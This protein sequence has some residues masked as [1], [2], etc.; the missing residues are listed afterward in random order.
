MD[1]LTQY[2]QDKRKELKNI[3]S[4]NTA[5]ERLKALDSD[6]RKAIEEHENTWLSNANI[7]LTEIMNMIRKKI[8]DPDVT[9]AEL[10]KALDVISVKYDLS[11]GK[12]TAR[13]K[14]DVEHHK[15]MTEEELDKRITMLS[16]KLKLPMNKTINAEFEVTKD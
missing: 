13:V 10:V 12:P 16:E 15:D 5:I 4:P 3:K 1:T 9:M 11:L 7:I 14:H 2:L 6:F 8:L